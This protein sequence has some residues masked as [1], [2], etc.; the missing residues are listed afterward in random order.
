VARRKTG[1]QDRWR[2]NLRHLSGAVASLL[3]LFW[4]G[5]AFADDSAIF[6]LVVNTEDKGETFAVVATDGDIMVPR[7]TL[8]DSGLRDVPVGQPIS[9]ELYGSLRALAPAVIYE[10]HP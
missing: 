4:C 7:S 1:R 8:I 9:G 3:A 2:T 10:L 5:P 6:R